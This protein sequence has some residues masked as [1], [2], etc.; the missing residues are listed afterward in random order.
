MRSH[1]ARGI[2]PQTGQGSSEKPS[3][4]ARVRLRSAP[5]LQHS[6]IPGAC[7]AQNSFYPSDGTENQKG[8]SL[9]EPWE[10]QK[11]HPQTR[12]N[13]QPPLPSACEDHDQ[14]SGVTKSLA[15]RRVLQPYEIHHRELKPTANLCFATGSG[16]ENAVCC[17][18]LLSHGRDFL[19]K[20][21]Q[22]SHIVSATS[23]SCSLL[24]HSD[25]VAQPGAAELPTQFLPLPFRTCF[26]SCPSE[27]QEFDL[28][29]CE[30]ALMP[31]TGL[32]KG[33]K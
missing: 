29:R 7:S 20:K 6:L 25:R 28:Q 4:A 5:S 24:R 8:G 19:G 2:S 18:R 11:Q 10:E 30:G 26:R 13:L 17:C 32:P 27:A 31:Q 1:G 33:Q 23:R 9:P 12:P 22:K 3:Q 15:L 16:S 14:I 21:K